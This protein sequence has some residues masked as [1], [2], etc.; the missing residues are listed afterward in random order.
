DNASV[1]GQDTDLPSLGSG[2]AAVGTAGA[3]LVTDRTEP[4]SAF[5][6]GHWI[7]VRDAADSLRGR[8]R[9]GAITDSVTPGDTMEL[10]PNG[11][12]TISLLDGFT[13]SHQYRFDSVTVTGSARLTS[14][15][16]V[17]AN[18]QPLVLP[19]GATTA[20][21][22]APD[23]VAS[24]VEVVAGSLPGGY[25]VEVGAGAFTD[26][27]GIVELRLEGG[28]RSV[29]VPWDGHQPISIPWLGR[30]G[31]RLSLIA[32]DGHG[33]FGRS[34][35]L[36]LA[37]LPPTVEI[38]ETA[39]IERVG[40]PPIESSILADEAAALELIERLDGTLPGF[41]PSAPIHGAAV[42]GDLL[43][44]R[45]GGTLAIW[46]VADPSAPRLVGRLDGVARRG[47]A[48]VEGSP[49]LYAPDDR[50]AGTSTLRL[51]WN[52]LDRNAAADRPTP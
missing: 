31:E 7:E 43:A 33:V 5:F 10:V 25:Q 11:A 6:V 30:A 3:S 14:L 8:W 37:P 9:I 20:N 48:F 35:E 16:P 47:V 44:V 39:G 15:D 2:T 17:F 41:D 12:E 45:F 34:R 4:I 40:A 29:V 50:D 21:P 23:A 18:G 36:H 46:H 26:A 19:L 27:D 28:D 42:D 22:A 51:D 32:V 49:V 52:L 1:V 38:S 13:W 24:A